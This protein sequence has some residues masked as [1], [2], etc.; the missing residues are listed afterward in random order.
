MLQLSFVWWVSDLLLVHG[1]YSGS[2]FVSAAYIVEKGKTCYNVGYL[3]CSIT[4][5]NYILVVQLINYNHMLVNVGWMKIYKCLA[6]LSLCVWD[7][8]NHSPATYLCSHKLKGLILESCNGKTK[9][10]SQIQSYTSTTAHYVVFHQMLGLWWLN[11][12]IR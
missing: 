5:T 7:K 12:S 8:T 3:I 1:C 4:S 6:L 11:Y 2:Y 9:S 10:K